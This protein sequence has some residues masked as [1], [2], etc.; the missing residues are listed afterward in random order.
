MLW[1]ACQTSPIEQF[2]KL[3]ND[4]SKD[5]VLEIVGSPQRTE[6]SYG[7]EKWAY[8]I[9]RGSRPSKETFMQVTFLNGHVVSSGEDAEEKTRLSDISTTDEKNEKSQKDY[10]EKQRAGALAAKVSPKDEAVEEESRKETED[11]F[12]EVKGH[13]GPVKSEDTDN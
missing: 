13:S 7:K 6:R 8:R 5:D 1:A 9:V 2:S 11:D 4:M 3:K 10:K 12:V